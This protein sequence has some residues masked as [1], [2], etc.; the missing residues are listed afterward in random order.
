M[1]WQEKSEY[2][3]TMSKLSTTEL[4]GLKATYVNLAKSKAE[5]LLEM[6]NFGY[7][8]THIAEDACLWT[9]KAN[10]IL[11]IL[12]ERKRNATVAAGVMALGACV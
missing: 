12:Q 4:E 2:K 7:P 6:L 9:T 1:D 10:L 3:A 5:K 11:Q 8:F